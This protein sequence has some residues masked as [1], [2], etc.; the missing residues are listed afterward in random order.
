MLD[1]VTIAQVYIDPGS[2]A[3]LWQVLAAAFVGVLFLVRKL[4]PIRHMRDWFRRARF[5]K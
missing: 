4:N 5:Q 1:F 3:L 2:G